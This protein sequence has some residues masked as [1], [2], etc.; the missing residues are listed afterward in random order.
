MHQCLS[1][2]KKRR[3]LVLSF[4]NVDHQALGSNLLARRRN[5]LSRNEMHDLNSDRK[6][7]TTLT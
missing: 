6:N 5:H 4:T 2:L 1:L 3:K 7:L